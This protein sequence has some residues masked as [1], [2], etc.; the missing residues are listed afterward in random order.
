MGAHAVGHNEQVAP[1][2]PLLRVLC[3]GHTEVVLVVCAA[4]S[5]V[6]QG[7]DGQVLFPVGVAVAHY[8]LSLS[9]AGF[10]VRGA[11]GKGCFAVSGLIFSHTSYSASGCE[12]TR[13]LG[14]AGNYWSIF[15]L[16]KLRESCFR[17]TGIGLG[18]P[19]VGFYTP[20]APGSGLER[21][22]SPERRAR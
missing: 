18:L 7:G 19:P 5:Q 14:A 15:S 11:S 3:Q 2:A 20:A 10:N 22:R 4:H 21:S 6:G 12:K 13:K 17:D 16:S 8:S 9:Q 1:L